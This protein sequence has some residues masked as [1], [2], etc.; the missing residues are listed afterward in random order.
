M[1]RADAKKI[2]QQTHEVDDVATQLRVLVVDMRSGLATRDAAHGR[3]RDLHRQLGAVITTL[4]AGVT[5]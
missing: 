2:V 3:L 1:P 4:G 5:S